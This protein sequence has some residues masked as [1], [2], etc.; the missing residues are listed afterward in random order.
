MCESETTVDYHRVRIGEQELLLPK[1]AESHDVMASAQETSS[2]M[3]YS[4]CAA[5]TTSTAGPLQNPSLLPENYK[6]RLA[7][8]NPI[9]METAAAGD[10]VSAMVVNEVVERE[11]V[12][13]RVLVNRGTR[14]RG[15]ILNLGSYRN[16]ERPKRSGLQPQ[17]HPVVAISFDVMEIDGA[18]SPLRVRLERTL[19]THD[20]SRWPE[21]T[22][23][24]TTDEE[25]YVIPRGFQSTWISTR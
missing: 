9:D 25:H 11:G 21:N 20:S 4:S 15:R 5:D 3:E 19:L 18:A 12:T 23:V 6:I 24:F 13:A 17:I 2:V 10:V 14:V 1:H 22:L 7:L 8:E 16:L